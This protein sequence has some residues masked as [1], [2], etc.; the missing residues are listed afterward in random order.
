MS[1]TDGW[2]D[3]QIHL[4]DGSSHPL[5]FALPP[6][7]QLVRVD[8]PSPYAPGFTTA[9]RITFRHSTAN[10]PPET[11]LSDRLRKY[12][13]VWVSSRAAPAGLTVYALRGQI[14]GD[15][16]ICLAE[17]AIADLPRPGYEVA[18]AEQLLRQMSEQLIER[19]ATVDR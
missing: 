3:A 8:D 11:A 4:L 17:Y 10:G 1:T 7:P 5:R 12:L 18:V 15:S 13:P 9:D 16:H 2:F 14:A 6:R 19:I